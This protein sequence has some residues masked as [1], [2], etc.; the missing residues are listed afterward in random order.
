MRNTDTRKAT[1]ARMRPVALIKNG[2]VITSFHSIKEAGE[3]LNIP[4]AHIC[5]NCRGKLRTAGGRKFIYIQ[6]EI[7]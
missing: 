5:M 1:A 6:N 7:R 3:K 2:A 4:S